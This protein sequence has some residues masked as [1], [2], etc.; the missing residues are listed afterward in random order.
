M[1]EYKHLQKGF[2]SLYRLMMGVTLITII[3]AVLSYFFLLAFYA[4]DRNWSTPLILSP[5]QSE[6][7]DFLPKVALLEESLVKKQADLSIATLT[8]QLVSQQ[9]HE[10]QALIDR[11]R[12]AAQKESSELSRTGGAMRV[13]LRQKSL[14]SAEMARD[15]DDVASLRTSIKADLAAGVITKDQ[16]MARRLALQSSLNTLSNDSVG[17]VVL[18]EQARNAL[19]AAATLRSN[20]ATSLTALQ[21]LHTEYQLIADKTRAMIETEAARRTMM[22]LQS[23]IAETKRVLAITQQSS[24]YQART[25][26]LPVVFVQYDNLSYATPGAPVYGCVLQIIACRRVGTVTEVFAA[27]AY[28]RHPLFKTETKGKYVS[29]NFVDQRA[30]ES[31]VVFLGH[32]PLLL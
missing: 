21:S 13:A 18:G 4:L 10:T 2:I 32:K 3:G 1:L 8:Y 5:T 9:I 14:N 12:G 30:S 17:Q 28:S 11:F 16:A 22:Q 25:H 24:Y 31:R 29:V 27:E 20:A 15:I 23:S 6:V 26:A 7:M 19:N